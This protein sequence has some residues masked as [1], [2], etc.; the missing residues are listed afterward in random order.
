MLLLSYL[1]NGQSENLIN[2]ESYLQHA[3][4]TLLLNEYYFI[5]DLFSMKF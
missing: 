3:D 1:S 2:K 5:P 4:K